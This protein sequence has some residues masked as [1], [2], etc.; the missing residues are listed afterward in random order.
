[1][2]IYNRT[3]VT[4]PGRDTDCILL[5]GNGL[6]GSQIA[7]SLKQTFNYDDKDISYSWSPDDRDSTIQLEKIR[8]S[9]LFVP[10]TLPSRISIVWAAG[11]AGFTA[12]EEDCQREL[13]QFRKILSFGESIQKAVEDVPVRFF[14]VS[15]AGALFE[16]QRCIT[17]KSLSSPKRPYGR[18]KLQQ[19]Q[20][21]EAS[22]LFRKYIY[23]PSSVY[24]EIG[25]GHRRGLVPV[26]LLAGFQ[27][28][29][30]KVSGNL[31]TLRDYVYAGDIGLFIAREIFSGKPQ[32]TAK[33]LALCSLKPTSI[34]EIKKE[35]EALLKRKIY[36]SM[37]LNPAN[38]LD[39]TYS[40]SCAP[41]YFWKPVDIKSGIGMIYRSLLCTAGAE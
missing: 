15:S 21:L 2:K 34:F 41:R 32:A 29:I 33:P 9:L 36:V 18:L 8:N 24:G 17:S 10:D 28:G 23:R 20:L 7:L 12:T 1:M 13:A 30:C 35:I 4:H 16:G 5:F 38:S 3:A 6:I 40:E 31:S 37:E 39:I 11:K 22:P 27:H 25:S 14:H 26:M 19:E